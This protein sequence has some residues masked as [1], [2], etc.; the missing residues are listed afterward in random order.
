MIRI[1]SLWVKLPVVLLLV[2]SIA[3]VFIVVPSSNNRAIL[4]IG[5]IL[6][7][8]AYFLGI[9]SAIINSITGMKP[10]SRLINGV[11]YL[12]VGVILLIVLALGAFASFQWAFGIFLCLIGA[13]ILIYQSRKGPKWAFRDVE[14]VALL[15][16]LLEERRRV[17]FEARLQKE[18]DK[19]RAKGF[20]A[21]QVGEFE[22]DQR[23]NFQAKVGKGYGLRLKL[24]EYMVPTYLVALGSDLGL[25]TLSLAIFGL[26]DIITAFLLL[27]L[28]VAVRLIGSQIAGATGMVKEVRLPEEV[29]FR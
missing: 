5:L 28:G 27:L 23:K 4:L 26:M 14:G 6:F 9:D 24:R 18:L 7:T 11:Y 1:N 2:I 10:L 19:V 21:K 17:K 3:S 22:E 29:T 12:L 20:T 16:H 15:R 8:E 13:S 25:A